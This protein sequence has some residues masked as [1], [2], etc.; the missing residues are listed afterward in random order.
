[1]GSSIC[2]GDENPLNQIRGPGEG[3]CMF[4]VFFLGEAVVY[5]LQL[6]NIPIATSWGSNMSH[7]IVPY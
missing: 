2:I 3:G 7:V 5:T 1:M 4:S 6:I